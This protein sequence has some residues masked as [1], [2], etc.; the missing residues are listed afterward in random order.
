MPRRKGPPSKGDLRARVQALHHGVP[1]SPENTRE[2]RGLAWGLAA[3]LLISDYLN[4]WNEARDDP[5]GARLLLKDAEY[6]VDKAL[7]VD[8]DFALAHYAKGLIHRAKGER[9]DALA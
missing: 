4:R 8:P 9:N 7:A 5:A 2:L 6:A 3:D 1:A